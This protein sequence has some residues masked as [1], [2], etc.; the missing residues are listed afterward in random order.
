MLYLILFH[1]AFVLKL[2][3]STPSWLNAFS[4]VQTQSVS[5]LFRARKNIDLVFMCTYGCLG[6][7][8]RVSTAPEAETTRPPCYGESGQKLVPSPTGEKSEQKTALL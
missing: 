8:P 3:V 2:C 1:N 4:V 5:L 7:R 6:T